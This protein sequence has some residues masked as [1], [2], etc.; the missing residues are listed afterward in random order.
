ME[1]IKSV[2]G[3]KQP[4]NK[5]LFSVIDKE[6]TLEKATEA[7][8]SLCADLNDPGKGIMFVFPLKMVEGIR[9]V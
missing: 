1:V 2:L 8:K 4:T 9:K 3:K 6:E 7:I 5:T